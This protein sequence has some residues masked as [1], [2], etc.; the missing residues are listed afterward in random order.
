MSFQRILGVFCGS[1]LLFLTA[2]FATFAEEEAFIPVQFNRL[3]P[4]FTFEAMG[5]IEIAIGFK[6]RVF[7]DL[8]QGVFVHVVE[9]RTFQQPGDQSA[10]VVERVD[11]LPDR[12]RPC[13]D[14]PQSLPT[15]FEE[16][17]F[18]GLGENT[19]GSGV[20]G[21]GRQFSEHLRSSQCEC[22][23]PRHKIIDVNVTQSLVPGRQ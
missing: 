22:L 14:V 20:S 15:Q 5:P 11:S 4:D 1:I 10:F 17:S 7:S 18:V 16:Q 13:A 23:M 2:I 3:P 8:I 21:Q 9:N 12:F 19:R 6:E